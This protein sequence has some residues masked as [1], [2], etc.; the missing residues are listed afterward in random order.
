MTHGRLGQESIDHEQQAGDHRSPVAALI[1][2]RRGRNGGSTYAIV[3]WGG[4][5]T[6]ASIVIALLVSLI[7]Q[8]APAFRH[9]GFGFIF[10][11]NWDPSADDFGAGVF[12]IDTMITT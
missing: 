6:F 2:R 4:A 8:S 11:G 3:R 10:S 9:S 1:A 12:I 5:V 7:W